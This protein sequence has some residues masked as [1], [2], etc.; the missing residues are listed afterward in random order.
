[1]TMDWNMKKEEVYL[2]CKPFQF[3]TFHMKLYFNMLHIQ[4]E[5]VIEKHYKGLFCNVCGRYPN[6]S[7]AG[8]LA[9][10]TSPDD[11]LKSKA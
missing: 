1:M 5:C 8:K 7:W 10:I 4:F 11:L 3:H 9:R 6:F 2:E